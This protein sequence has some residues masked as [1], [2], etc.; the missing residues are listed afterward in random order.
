[1]LAWRGVC[2]T[3]YPRVGT[4]SSLPLMVWP[5]LEICKLKSDAHVNG[6][7]SK[8]LAC[9]KPPLWLFPPSCVFVS[10]N[11]LFHRPK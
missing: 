2:I 9:S 1:M 5:Q 3:P 6:L 7:R 11:L 10:I 4:S 8:G